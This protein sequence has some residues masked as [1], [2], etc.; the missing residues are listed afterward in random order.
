MTSMGARWVWASVA[1]LACGRRGVD[2]R[3][4]A[5]VDDGVDASS[6]DGIAT[7]VV[8]LDSTSCDDVHAS[9]MFCDGFENGFVRWGGAP[10]GTGSVTI[11]TAQ[12]WRGAGALRVE[13]F[14]QGDTGYVTYALP[15]RIMSGDVFVRMYVRA[16]SG[17]TITALGLYEL[18]GNSG[19]IAVE[20][21]EPERLHLWNSTDA[22]GDYG[23]AFV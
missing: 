14:A 7:D 21:F 13:T 4:D 18:I 3:F 2:S 11:D 6:G 19:N 23:P 5:G 9:A 16:P 22:T 10:S 1:L 12:T 20:L 17:F 8:R 15:N